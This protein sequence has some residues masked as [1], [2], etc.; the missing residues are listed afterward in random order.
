MSIPRELAL[1]ATDDGLRLIQKPVREL[2]RLRGPRHRFKGGTVTEAN[3]WLQRTGLRGDRLELRFELP[4][5]SPASGAQ[6]L[7]LLQGPGEETIVGVTSA[8]DWRRVFLDRTKSGQVTFHPKFPGV[9][10]TPWFDHN[11]P[12]KLQVF[13]DACSVE[14]FVNDGEQVLTALVLPSGQGRGL[15][16]FGPDGSSVLHT[17][18]WPL[19][20][21]NPDRRPSY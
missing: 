13:V 19:G 18:A 2:Q 7:K 3:A 21:Q 15:E 11:R 6:G 5:L 1:R 9:Y 17:E 10:A 14:V 16:F 12:V 8:G 20:T 4:S